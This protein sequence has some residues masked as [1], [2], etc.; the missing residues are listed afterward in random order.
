M[1]Y[2]SSQIDTLILLFVPFDFLKIVFIVHVKRNYYLNSRTLKLI[3]TSIIYCS[4]A[5]LNI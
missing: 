3:L 2:E 5:T 1:I 4:Y